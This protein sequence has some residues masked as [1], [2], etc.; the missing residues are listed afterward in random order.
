M[1]YLGD[2]PIWPHFL[3]EPFLYS[4]IS[5][6]YVQYCFGLNYYINLRLENC[7]LSESALATF[8]LRPLPTQE[9]FFSLGLKWIFGQSHPGQVSLQPCQTLQF[10]S[11]ISSSFRHLKRS[12]LAWASERAPLFR[13]SMGSYLKVSTLVTHPLAYC[14]LF[15]SL[16]L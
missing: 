15:G 5:C 1:A 11:G 7:H 8:L 9:I 12:F 6:S 13:S 4:L 10:Y 2:V 14:I 16:D 3:E